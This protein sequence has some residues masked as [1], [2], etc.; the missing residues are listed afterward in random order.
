M[1]QNILLNSGL[2][3]YVSCVNQL[4]STIHMF[5]AFDVNTSSEIRGVFQDLSSASDK[6]WH[7]GF[8]Y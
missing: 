5:R 8:L 7:E 6:V 4:I 2:R 1:I 3:P